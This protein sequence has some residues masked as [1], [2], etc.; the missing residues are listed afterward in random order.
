MGVYGCCRFVVFVFSW[1]ASFGR[2][3]GNV[4]FGVIGFGF[5]FWFYV[6]VLLFSCCVFLVVDFSVEF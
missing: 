6:L 4:G 1:E 3:V 5:M 2:V